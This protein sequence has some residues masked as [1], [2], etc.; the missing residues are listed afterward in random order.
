MS[1]LSKHVCGPLDPRQW[2][3]GPWLGGWGPWGWPWQCAC[4]VLP[5]CLQCHL[6]NHLIKQVWGA[7]GRGDGM[8]W[9]LIEWCLWWGWG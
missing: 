7:G 6:S 4:P 5:V 9:A 1:H 8:E 2:V 3:Q